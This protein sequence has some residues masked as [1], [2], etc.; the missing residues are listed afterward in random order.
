MDAASSAV[1]AGSAN[2]VLQTFPGQGLTNPTSGDITLGN[3]RSG[4]NVFVAN[5]GPTAGSD[6]L[7]ASASTTVIAA[8]ATFDVNGGGGGGSVGT[9]A[10][11]MGLQPAVAGGT[12]NVEARSQSGGVFLKLQ[13]SPAVLNVGSSASGG[14]TGITTS[15]GGPVFVEASGP[16]TPTALTT[17]EAITA[18][19]AGTVTLQTLATSL[20]VGPG[21]IGYRHGHA[22]LRRRHHPF[23]RRIGRE[24]R[25]KRRPRRRYRQ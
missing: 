7:S 20:S 5:N 3:V 25:G 17:T 4:G 2:V 12:I 10:T 16:G 14:L 21:R 22:P 24:N 8:S 19:G 13:I 1:N 18:A 6:I 23:G 15:G 11:A 9:A